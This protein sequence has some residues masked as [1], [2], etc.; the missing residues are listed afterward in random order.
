MTQFAKLALGYA[1]VLIGR[2]HFSGAC[3]MREATSENVIITLSS[4]NGRGGR[5][6]ERG[7]PPAQWFV[8]VDV[9][10]FILG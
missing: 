6:T 7:G 1:G 10:Y 9:F 2:G 8:I 5:A 4:K 3:F